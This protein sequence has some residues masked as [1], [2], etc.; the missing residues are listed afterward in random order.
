MVSS[1]KVNKN[2][3]NYMAECV[4]N[5]SKE[6]LKICQD[7]AINEGLPIMGTYQFSLYENILKKWAG[8]VIANSQMGFAGPFLFASAEQVQLILNKMAEAQ[9]Q[10]FTTSGR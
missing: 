6:K 4:K 9:T 8:T 5:L 3:A 1:D 10:M 7:A 2:H